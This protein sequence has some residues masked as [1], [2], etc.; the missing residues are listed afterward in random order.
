MANDNKI[1]LTRKL[2]SMQLNYVIKTIVNA[3]K[4]TPFD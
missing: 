1:K 4:T 2:Q 3:T